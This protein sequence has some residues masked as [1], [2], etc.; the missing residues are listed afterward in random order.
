MPS[1]ALKS[2]P[3]DECTTKI[4]EKALVCLC[5]LVFTRVL[6]LEFVSSIAFAFV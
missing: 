5:M 3:N 6:P 1:P 4:N 2:C